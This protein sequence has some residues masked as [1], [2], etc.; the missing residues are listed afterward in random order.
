MWGCPGLWIGLL[1]SLEAKQEGLSKCLD[2]SVD[3]SEG[4]RMRESGWVL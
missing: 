4:T 1:R 2:A 3:E